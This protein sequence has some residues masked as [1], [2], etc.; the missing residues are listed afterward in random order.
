MNEL[1]IR[2]RISDIER[3]IAR[4]PEG[5]ITKKRINDKEY[6]YHRVTRNGKRTESYVPFEDVEELRS[7]IDKRKSLKNELKTLKAKVEDNAA[8]RKNKKQASDV[9]IDAV[10][11]YTYQLRPLI[12]LVK[13]YKKRECI[14]ALRDYIF[15]DYI[16]KVFILYG[17]RRTGKTTMIRQIMGEMSDRELEQTAFIQVSS[18]DTLADIYTAL[19][20]LK[21]NGY[22][23]VFID[24]VT[25]LEDFVEGAALF[26]DIF[27]SSGMKIVL[28]GT[29]SLGFIFSKGEQ[30]YDRCIL[31]HTTFIPYREFEE[32]LGIKGIDEFIR[33]GGT[34]SLSGINYNAY[35]TFANEQ[36]TEEYIDTAIAKNIQHSLKIYQYGGHF[37]SLLDLYEKGELTNV[38]NRVVENINHS[39]TRHVVERTFQS[40][41]LSVT[42]AN[43]LR[44]RENP[45]NIREH[46]DFDEVTKGIMRVLEI[47]NK[48][49]QSID[50]EDSHMSQ[51]REYLL[52]LDLIMEIDL[53][54]IPVN[55]KR[56][57]ITVITQP[58]L[59]YAQAKAVVDNVLLDASFQ[60]LSITERSRIVERLMS[61]IRG[62]MMEEIILLETKIAN[63]NKHVFKLQFD[64]GEFDMVIADPSTLTCKIYEI[65]YSKEIVKDQYQH[66]TDEQKCAMTVHRYGEITGKYLIYRGPD[67]SD[68]DIRYLNVEEYLKSL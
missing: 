46:L 54:N 64:V 60:E 55:S 17:L 48:E 58:G 43:L 39:F 5:S 62:R 50:I 10:F 42:A 45:V 16:E 52:L 56:S 8:I 3:E 35:A 32:V 65:K 49:E 68:G 25:L 41:D 34:M 19:G 20:D 40:H 1:E 9:R 36:N 6:F 44:D 24:E 18:Q 23:Y 22:K 37:R 4:L 57:T 47:L 12:D 28:S 13:G 31:L 33:Y 38:I 26:A 66:L 14:S 11:R 30:L 59:R 61:E 21:D 27:V 53:E 7:S 2:Q 51:I 63:P 67:S 29:D 15:G